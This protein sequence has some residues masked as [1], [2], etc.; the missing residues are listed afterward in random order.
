MLLFMHTPGAYAAV[1]SSNDQQITSKHKGWVAYDAV[2]SALTS[3]F[4]HASGYRVPWEGGLG[5]GSLHRIKYIKFS[6]SSL[7]YKITN[8]MPLT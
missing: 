5:P 2:I 4:K 6:S 7:D 8:L 3:D 1:S